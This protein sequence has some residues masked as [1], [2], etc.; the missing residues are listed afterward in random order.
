MVANFVLGTSQVQNEKKKSEGLCKT[1]EAV[2]LLGKVFNGNLIM[3][4]DW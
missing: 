1:H 3:W 4:K 2:M